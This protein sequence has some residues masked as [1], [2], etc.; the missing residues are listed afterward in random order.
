MSDDPY[1]GIATLAP[2]PQ[3]PAAPAQ[4]G[5]TP[6]ATPASDPYAAFATAAPDA[7]SGASAPAGGPVDHGA[8]T[9]GMLGFLDGVPF[10]GPS[11]VSGAQKTGAAIA[12]LRDG[13]TYADHLAKVQNSSKATADAHPWA[14]AAGE[15][16]GG[17]VGTAPAIAAAPEGPSGSAEVA[18]PP[19]CSP[20]PR[21]GPGSGRATEPRGAMRRRSGG[22]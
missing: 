16:A 21:Q 20:E 10:A 6:P 1:A 17:V 18:S 12:T 15:V 22:S 3:A 13:G 4:S 14:H 9:S 8:T 7:P 5:A 19:V 2:E 11:L